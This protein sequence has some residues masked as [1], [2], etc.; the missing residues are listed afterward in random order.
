[1]RKIKE[2]EP[3]KMLKDVSNNISTSALGD[4]YLRFREKDVEAISDADIC[5][6]CRQGLMPQI[7]VPLA[8]RR[9]E[10]D[11]L[12]GDIYDGELLISLTGIPAEY[13]AANVESQQ[14]V[15]RILGELSDRMP[16]DMAVEVSRLKKL[17]GGG[18]GDPPKVPPLKVPGT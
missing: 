18:G 2:F 6:A 17:F 11:P 9:L 10:K 15:S 16:M 12:A 13:W 1:M 14:V 4:W 8:L 5:I 7:L 3:E